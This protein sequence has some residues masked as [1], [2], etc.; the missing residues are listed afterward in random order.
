MGGNNEVASLALKRECEAAIKEIRD[1]D[2]PKDCPA[3]GAVS[4]GLIA[5]LRCKVAELEVARSRAHEDRQVKRELYFLAAKI[6]L[7]VGLIA[8]GLSN[9]GRL[10]GGFF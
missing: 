8:A 5:L 3:H 7:I 10:I 6:G 2:P 4:R 9:V 1:S